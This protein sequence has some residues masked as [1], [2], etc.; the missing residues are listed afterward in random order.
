MSLKYNPDLL[1]QYLIRKGQALTL[2]KCK[3]DL[4][5]T[6]LFQYFDDTTA[7]EDFIYNHQNTS[8]LDIFNSWES[9]IPVEVREQCLRETPLPIPMC[10]GSYDTKLLTHQSVNQPCANTGNIYT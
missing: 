7:Q 3:Y 2:L 8:C 4:S 1:W 10:D 6:L 9:Q 5:S